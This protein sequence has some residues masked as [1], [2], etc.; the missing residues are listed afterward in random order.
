MQ[1]IL[2][3]ASISQNIVFF[4]KTNGNP[5]L[6]PCLDLSPERYKGQSTG[7]GLDIFKFRLPWSSLQSQPNLLHISFYLG[8][9]TPSCSDICLLVGPDAQDDGN[10]RPR[11]L[12]S[13]A[14]TAI[15]DQISNPDV[16]IHS[17][18]SIANQEQ[19]LLIYLMLTSFWA[20]SISPGELAS[21]MDLPPVPGQ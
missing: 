1:V 20:L 19:C 17:C 3:T 14:E 8:G 21:E 13:S 5:E 15:M 2:Q 10:S 9:G 18:A 7:L 4:L 6:F 11:H 16:D 12:E